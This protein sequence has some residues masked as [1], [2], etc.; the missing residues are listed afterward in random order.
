LLREV[1]AQDVFAPASRDAAPKVSKL[2]HVRNAY[3]EVGPDDSEDLRRIELNGQATQEEE[4]RYGLIWGIKS[5]FLSYVSRLHDGRGSI[6]GGATVLGDNTF[7]FPAV[8][9]S[10]A[11]AG[12]GRTRSW[13][14]QGDVRF[15]AHMG[16]LFVR[17][18]APVISLKGDAAELTI[19]DPYGKS[20][21]ERVPLVTMNLQPG[22]TSSGVDVWLG[23]DVRLTEAGAELFND[24]YEPGESFEQLRFALPAG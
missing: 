1:L 22:P 4:F 10:A 24:V 20:G 19:A 14:F 15:S 16:M 8:G 17:V 9:G 11:T 6:S 12:S 5:S 21:A 23:V 18:A 3:R 2:S 13:A 7:H